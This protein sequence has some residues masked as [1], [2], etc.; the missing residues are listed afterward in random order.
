MGNRPTLARDV[1]ACILDAYQIPSSYLPLTRVCHA[2][3]IS[4]AL[5]W[6]K[7]DPVQNGTLCTHGPIAYISYNRNSS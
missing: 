4:H 3:D 7:T 2:M 6:C 1:L 5:A